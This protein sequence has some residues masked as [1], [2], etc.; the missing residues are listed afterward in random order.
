MVRETFVPVAV[1]LCGT[2]M[3]PEETCTRRKTSPLGAVR[4]EPNYS[5]MVRR[6]PAPAPI[7]T[8]HPTP[9]TTPVAERRSLP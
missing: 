4:V 1:V 5:D 6:S 7:I 2:D 3:A 9:R 8:T